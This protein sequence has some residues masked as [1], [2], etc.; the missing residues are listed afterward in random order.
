MPQ[1]K[2]EYEVIEEFK[3]IALKLLEKY[4]DVLDGINPNLLRCVG[5]TN[6]DPKEGKPLFELQQVR[7]PQRLDLPYD[8]YVVVNMHDW[9]TFDES[10]QAALIF[11]VLCS[12]S[13][14]GD[15]K[16]VPFDLKDHSV[17]VRSLGVDYMLRP[18]I[19]NIL[20]DNIKWKKE[21]S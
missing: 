14:D 17:V 2:P 11:D 4:P 9:Q 20:T 5:V 7:Y 12:V 10:H 15:G 13:R 21:A 3:T 19:P 6:K 16:V 8:F 18:D 1:V